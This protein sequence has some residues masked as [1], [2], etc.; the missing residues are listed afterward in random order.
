MQNQEHGFK[1][2]KEAPPAPLCWWRVDGKFN[3]RVTVGDKRIRFFHYIKRLPATRKTKF[4][5]KV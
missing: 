1:H 4:I 5:K 3:L 2:N